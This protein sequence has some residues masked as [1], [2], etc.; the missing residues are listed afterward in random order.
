MKFVTSINIING[1]LCSH[2]ETREVVRLPEEEVRKVDKDIGLMRELL[3]HDNIVEYLG[4][5][6]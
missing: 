5:K 6:R 3:R 2:R 1:P 4:M